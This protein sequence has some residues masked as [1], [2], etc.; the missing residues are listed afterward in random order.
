MNKVFN[1]QLLFPSF[2][3]VAYTILYVATTD[4]MSMR[5]GVGYSLVQCD[6]V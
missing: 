5:V 3:R 2:Q 4:R 6:K 1:N